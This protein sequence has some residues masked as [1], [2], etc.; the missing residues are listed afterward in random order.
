MVDARKRS[1]EERARL[2]DEAAASIDPK[3]ARDPRSLA[4]L[5]G[6]SIDATR[7]VRARDY[8]DMELRHSSGQQLDCKIEMVLRDDAPDRGDG[9]DVLFCEVSDTG[10][11]LLFPPVRQ[12]LVS[13][14]NDDSSGEI[15]VMIRGL[16]SNGQEWHELLSLHANED[17]AGPEWVHMLG[18]EPAPPKISRAPSFLTPPARPGASHATPKK[19]SSSSL[20]SGSPSLKDVEVPIGEV[21]G[22]ESRTWDGNATHISTDVE[23][24][25]SLPRQSGTV[26]RKPLPSKVGRDRAYNMPNSPLRELFSSIDSALNDGAASP[27]AASLPGLKRAKAKKYKSSPVSPPLSDVSSSSYTDHPAP[28]RPIH[29]RTQPEVTWMSND[30]TSSH[31]KDFSVWLPS[32]TLPSDESESESE[33]EKIVYK[34]YNPPHTPTRPSV[35]RKTSSVPSSDLPAIPRL[36]ESSRMSPPQRDEETHN[37]SSAPAK[38][39]KRPKGSNEPGRRS[40][41]ESPAP[42]QKKRFSI[43]SLTPNFLKRN[44]RSSSPLKHQYEPSVVSDSSSYSISSDDEDFDDSLTSESSDEEHDIIDLKAP[45]FN[46]AEVFSKAT[47]PDSV[48][49]LPENTLAPSQSA[50]QSPYTPYRTIPQPA[51]GASRTVASIFG[52]SDRGAWESLHPEECSVIVTGGLIEAFEMNTSPPTSSGDTEWTSPSTRGFKPIVAFELTPL[53]PLR[54]GTAL[55]ISIRSPPTVNSLIRTSNNVMFRSRNAEECESL[56]SLINHARINNPTYVALQ[57]AR[58]PFNESTWAAAMERRNSGQKPKSSWFPTRKSS[59]YRS[60]ASRPRSIN[61]DSSVGTNNSAFSA[62]RR[63]SGSSNIFNIGKST[64]TSRQG[65]HSATSDSLSSGSSSTPLAFDLSQGTPLGITNAKIRL[66]YRETATK[67]R[68]MGSARLTIMIPPR[69]NPNVPAS[70]RTTGLEKRIL[71]QGKTHG[72]TLLDVTLGESCFERVARTGIAVSVWEDNMG[73]NGELGHVAASGGVGSSRARTFMIQL[74][75][76]SA[77]V[78]TGRDGFV[79]SVIC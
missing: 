75:S 10:R 14:R 64:I 43:P 12:D 78:S 40:A 68:D 63:F 26:H 42:P 54:R 37:P 11:W 47:P 62:L 25:V 27:S 79:C 15:V 13:A 34:A 39:Q 20:K 23:S 74:K 65:S 9:G 71:V 8:F 31:K 4:P 1:N 17:E 77:M 36:R 19:A 58:G 45:M 29:S 30:S 59:T 7:Y 66:H 55:D 16:Q 61:T 6:V 72:E 21:A 67:W 69:P 22:S 38:L 32:S 51:G 35:H 46:P 73:P 60:K 76:V 18:L 3:R 44:R 50:S 33:E 52:W 48:A 2:E 70:P 41:P 56:Y 49:S 5:A 53:V 57:N 24:E 28:L